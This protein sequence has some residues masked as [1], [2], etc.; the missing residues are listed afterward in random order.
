M[1]KVLGPRDVA[2]ET[3][4]PSCLPFMINLI[5][6]DIEGVL[7]TAKAGAEALGRKDEDYGRFARL[8]DPAG[9]KVELWRPLH[10]AKP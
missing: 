9:V 3:D 5:V 1:A 7:A 6:D 10:G 8:T 2:P 4:Y